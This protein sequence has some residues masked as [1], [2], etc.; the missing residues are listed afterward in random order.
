MKALRNIVDR[1]I[2]NTRAII[3]PEINYEAPARLLEVIERE[4]INN[5]MMRIKNVQ[6]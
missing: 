4:K 2:T 1:K 5:V 3:I 6:R